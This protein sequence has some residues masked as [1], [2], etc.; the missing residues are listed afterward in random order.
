MQ[1]AFYTEKEL[2]R[3]LHTGP[4]GL[5]TAAVEHSRKQYGANVL[6]KQKHITLL[7]RFLEAFLS[8]FTV[9]LLLAGYYIAGDRCSYGCSRRA[10]LY[11]RCH[12]RRAGS[13]FRNSP[14]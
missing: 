11:N 6:A 13:L 2:F 4:S 8:P 1:A 14:V 12:H 5:D 3:M 9:V 7:R 10:Q